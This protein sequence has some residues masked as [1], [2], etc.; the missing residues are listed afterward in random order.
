METAQGRA[1]LKEHARRNRVVGSEV[2]LRALGEIRNARTRQMISDPIE[3]L[4]AE[5][6]EA[7]A[8]DNFAIG[9]LHAQFNDPLRLDSGGSVLYHGANVGISIRF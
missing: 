4:S 8:P 6:Q 9:F 3:I 7:L 1:F 5:L 2:V